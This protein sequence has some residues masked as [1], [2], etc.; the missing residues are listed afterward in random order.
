[1]RFILAILMCLYLLTTA[2]PTLAKDKKAEKPMDQ[3]AMMELW[4]KLATPASRINS[5]PRWPAVGPPRPRNG[6][7]QAS[8]PRN[9]PALRR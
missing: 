7:S 1:M 5:S 9:P 8:L 2:S 6:W 4:K 3:Q